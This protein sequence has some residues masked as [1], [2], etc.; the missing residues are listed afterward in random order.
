V[1]VDNP[2]LIFEEAA[3]RRRRTRLAPDGKLVILATDHPGRR[4]TGIPGDPLGMGD[5]HSYLARAL[6]VLLAPGCDGIMGTTDFL[7]DLLI[8]NALLRDA[9]GP[10]LLDDKVLV[11][12]M[13]RADMREWP[14]KST[15]ASP[16]SRHRSLPPCGLKAAS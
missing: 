16:R 10:E 3:R 9:G 1:R 8:L 5:R 2:E 15:T 6:R 4:V 11:G 7:E 14:A 13:N 12:C